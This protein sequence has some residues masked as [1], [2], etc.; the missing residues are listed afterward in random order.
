[1]VRIISTRALE[2]ACN[3]KAC[4]P[5]PVGRGGSGNGG[6]SGSP[7]GPAARQQPGSG[8]SGSPVR[9]NPIGPGA[10]RNPNQD[11]IDKTIWS[12]EGKAAAKAARPGDGDG[13]RYPRGGGAKTE[14]MVSSP[15]RRNGDGAYYAPKKASS[16]ER[17]GGTAGTTTAKKSPSTVKEVAGY[18]L[19]RG[20]RIHFAQSVKT[21]SSVGKQRNGRIGVSFTSGGVTDVGAGQ[22]F[23]VAPPAKTVKAKASGIPKGNPGK[24]T[25]AKPV[26]KKWAANP[27]NPRNQQRHPD[28]DRASKKII[29][30]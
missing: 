1:M 7:V 6:R 5:P 9:P 22:K 25:E 2:F 12:A 17:K 18:E 21:V 14:K 16:T 13:A 8:R 3:S 15:S 4:A 19:K 24:Y 26:D 10:G 11:M 27:N 23:T 28:D 29:R 20:D 30:P